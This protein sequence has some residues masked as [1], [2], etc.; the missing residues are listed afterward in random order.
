VG[1]T[2]AGV[3]GGDSAMVDRAPGAAGGALPPPQ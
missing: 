1:A 3:G 2:L